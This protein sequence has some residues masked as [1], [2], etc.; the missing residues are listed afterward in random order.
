[1]FNVESYQP[2]HGPFPVCFHIR[3]F[4][5]TRIAPEPQLL[6]GTPPSTCVAASMSR[7]APVPA[8]FGVA[9]L[10]SAWLSHKEYELA[11]VHK[12]INLKSQYEN[13]ANRTSVLRLT[14]TVRCFG[15]SCSIALCAFL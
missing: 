4:G 14:L 1:M 10:S 6:P 13:K 9:R 11:A 5:A 15:L 12:A 2:S 7:P 3:L 8:A